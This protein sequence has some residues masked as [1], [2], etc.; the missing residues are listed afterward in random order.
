MFSYYS[1]LFFLMWLPGTE[2]GNIYTLTS[3][4]QTT[5]HIKG[6]NIF[7]IVQFLHF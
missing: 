2:T 3:L 7:M 6:K 4:D 5:V 1:T